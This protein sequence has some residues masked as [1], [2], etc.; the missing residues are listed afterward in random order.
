MESGRAR[1]KEKEEA[2]RLARGRLVG[3]VHVGGMEGVPKFPRDIII[4][5]VSG[6]WEAFV[7]SQ[8]LR[9]GGRTAKPPERMSGHGW[10]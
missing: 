6:G 5:K 1:E 3:V 7:F 9:E 4:M 10:A 8:R 2:T